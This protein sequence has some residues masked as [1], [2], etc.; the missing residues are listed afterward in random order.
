[1]CCDSDGDSVTVLAWFCLWYL[2]CDL[3]LVQPRCHNCGA[4]CPHQACTLSLSPATDNRSNNVSTDTPDQLVSLQRSGDWQCNTWSGCAAQQPWLECNQCNHR[5]Q[6]AGSRNVLSVVH[7]DNIHC[8]H[9]AIPT[10]DRSHCGRPHINGCS[11]DE[12][13]K[14]VAVLV[15]TKL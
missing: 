2:W 3:F 1:M 14:I 9:S 12:A 15:D 10:Q 5:R 11:A 7:S 6:S 13:F 8:R 4:V